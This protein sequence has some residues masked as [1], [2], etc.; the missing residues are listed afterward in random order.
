MWQLINSPA[1]PRLVVLSGPVG[2]LG[3]G[4]LG[5]SIKSHL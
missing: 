2:A 5:Q 4:H 1:V 3:P